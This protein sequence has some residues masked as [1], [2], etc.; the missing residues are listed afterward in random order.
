MSWI[1]ELRFYLARMNKRVLSSFEFFSLNESKLYSKKDFGVIGPLP[2]GEFKMRMNDIFKVSENS[3]NNSIILKVKD[4][5][6]E[7]PSNSCRIDNGLVEVRTNMNWFRN[8]DNFDNF[9]DL[10]EKYISCQNE[11]K[12]HTLVDDV[13]LITEELGILDDV[14]DY[15]SESNTEIQGSLSN[16]MEFE[17][18][19]STQDDPLKKI[20]LYQNSDEIHPSIDVRRKGSKFS[21]RYRTPQG[22]FES[23]HDNLTSILKSPID[24][25]LVSV[26]CGKDG[27]VDQK[28]LVNHLFKLFK[29]HSWEKPQ[30]G[31]PEVVEKYIQESKEIKRVMEILKNS[32][33][34]KH[35]EEMYTDARSKFISKK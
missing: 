34:E 16:G 11:K 35:I 20:L 19:K 32:I 9:Y 26:C 21:C 5:S 24:K 22:K 14:V 15:D 3:E 31:S 6:V 30:N 4:Q 28:E 27:E 8:S 23:E 13:N 29:Y 12:N 7:L 17:F 2:G 10:V 1:S 18:Y 25:Y 33:P